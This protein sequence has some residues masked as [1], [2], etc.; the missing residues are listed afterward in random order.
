MMMQ[1]HLVGLHLQCKMG[2][3]LLAVLCVRMQECALIGATFPSARWRRRTC[4]SSNG[5][6]IVMRTRSVRQHHQMGVSSYRKL[7]VCNGRLTPDL[8]SFLKAIKGTCGRRWRSRN[9]KKCNAEA[10]RQINLE[11]LLKCESISIRQDSSNSWLAI[12][13]VGCDDELQIH[14]GLLGVI[15]TA[16]YVDQTAEHLFDA[17]ITVYTKA[18][19]KNQNLPAPTTHDADAQACISIPLLFTSM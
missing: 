19:K 17:M 2:Y 18:C 10:T 13:F 1:L 3:L 5:I 4:A 7:S 11:N 14:R 6:L 12:R 9:I 16:D 8:D 15:E